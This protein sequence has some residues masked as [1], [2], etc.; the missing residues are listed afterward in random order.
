MKCDRQPNYR[1]CGIH[2][3]ANVVSILNGTDPAHIRY[4]DSESL[5]DHLIYCLEAKTFTLFPSVS[6][7]E[8]DD[9]IHTQS[10]VQTPVLKKAPQKV[11]ILSVFYSRIV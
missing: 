9:V 1:D 7:D 2:A 8:D 10:I 11:I 5:R 6:Y 4:L 3:I